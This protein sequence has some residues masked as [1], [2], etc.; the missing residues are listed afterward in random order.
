[1]ALMPEGTTEY[2]ESVQ[3]GFYT[4]EEV[5]KLS[6]KTITEP[7]FLDNLGR[8]VPG[9]LYDPALGPLDEYSICKTCGQISFQ[10]PGHW[11]RIPLALKVY[12]PL[13]FK[14]L[15]DLLKIT[16]FKCH[17][18]RVNKLQVQ[19]CVSKLELI[20]K[21]DVAGALDLVPSEKGH[22][23]HDKCVRDNSK[24]IWTSLQLSEA[25]FVLHEF[26]K[27][28]K[29]KCEKCGYK[30]PTLTCPT[31]GWIKKKMS[32][33]AV[34]SNVINE[35]KLKK[36]LPD[37]SEHES[38]LSE[39]ET[40]GDLSVVT[41]VLEDAELKSSGDVCD[42][43]PDSKIDK[44]LSSVLVYQKY[45]SS[46][47]LLP[48]EAHDRIQLLWEFETPLC[49]FI[50][51]IQ[52]ESFH[53]SKKKGNY[54]MFF[55]ESL[56]VSPIKFR[57]PS[58][59]GDTLQAN[60]QK[61]SW[62]VLRLT[63]A[64]ESDSTHSISSP[65][66]AVQATTLTMTLYS[67]MKMVMEHPQTMLLK[68]VLQSNI[69]LGNAY[70][71]KQGSKFELCCR[72]LQRSVN[73]LF[74]N[75]A[76]GQT[77]NMYAGICQLIEKKEGIFRQNMMGKRVNNAC[78]SVISPDP[79]LAVNEIG[80]P[81]H[82]ATRLTY[83]ERVTPLN[84][85]KLGIAIVNGSE[86]HPG[87]THY[88]DKISMVKLP[89]IKRKRRAIS[90]KLHSSRGVG[91]QPGEIVDNEF[92]EKFVYRHIQDGDI[93]LVNRQP[94]LHK[95]GI[96]AHVVRVLTGEKTLRMHYANCST[97]N[98]DFDG[99]EMNVHFP[100]D[101]ISRSEALNI[102]NANNQYVVPTSGD[103]KRGLIQWFLWMVN[104]T[105]VY[106]SGSYC[107]CRTSYKEGYLLTR[108]EYSHLL[109]SS[110]VSS[111]ARSSFR[112]KSGQKVSTI[113]FE[114][115]IQPVCPAILKPEPLWTGKQVITSLLNHIS[116][117][118]G[119][120]PLT[121]EKPGKIK[122][123]YFGS[124][125]G[126]DKLLIQK[127]EFVHGVIDKNQFDK[128]GLIHAIQELYSS[129]IAGILLS[130]LSRLFTVFLQMHGFTCG[131]DDLLIVP[132]L[133]IQM[134]RELQSCDVRGAKEHA[135]FVGCEDSSIDPM[136]LQLEIEK[137][138]RVN[139]E[140]AITRLDGVMASMLNVLTSNVND[141]LFPKGLLKPFPKNCLSLMTSSGAKG[142]L[143][144]FTQ[145]SSSLGQQELEGKRVP[146]M[147]SGKTLPCFPPWDSASRAGGFISDR[148]LT[149]LR[150]QEY[151]FHCMAGREGL[152]DTAV[153][154]SR[155]GYLQRCL[156]KNLEGLKVCYD[157]TVRDADN[158][159][160]QF[161]YGEDGVD[162][163]KTSFISEFNILAA[164][165]ERLSDHYEG[166][167]F[168]ES[169]GYIKEFPEALEWKAKDFI[170]KLSK[171]QL[172]S[173]LTTKQLSSKLTKKQT[174]S[175][176]L[177]KKK[178]FMELMKLKYLSSLA[179]PG[180]PVG[181]I[182]AQSIGEPSTQMT[183]NTFHH[184]GRGD[185]NVTLGIPR[186]Q[187]ILMRASENIQTPVLTCPLQNGKTENDAKCLA[188]TLNKVSVADVVESM[189]VRVEH[190]KVHKGKVST[191]YKLKM[192]LFHP[193]FYPEFSDITLEKIEEILEYRF[194][195]ELEEVI[196]SHLTMLS[197]ISG[198]NNSTQNSQFESGK[199]MDPDNI[200]NQSQ[201]VEDENKVGGVEIDSEGED[202]ADG[203]KR[204]RQSADDM[205]YEDHDEKGKT[206]VEGESSDIDGE[207]SAGESEVDEVDDVEDEI[208]GDDD[209]VFDAEDESKTEPVSKKKSSN[210]E[211]KKQK[212]GKKV[213][214]SVREKKKSDRSVYVEANGLDFEVHLKFTDEPHILLS[215]IAQRA[216]KNVY[217]KRSGKIDQ[218]S[219]TTVEHMRNKKTLALQTAGV[220]FNAFAKLQDYL[221]INFMST[222]DIHAMLHTYG[223]EA[224]RATII[225]QVEAVF[226][227]YGISVNIRHL[228]LVA[229]FMTHSGGYRPMSRSGIANST[230]P[231]SK[232]SFE[233]ASNF[234][235]QA[236]YHGEVDNLESPSARI[237]LGLPVKMGTGSFDVLLNYN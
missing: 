25:V 101:E 11:G 102:V 26:M 187:E 115:E 117:A 114:D 24:H 46:G 146:R 186:L 56:L 161:C 162:V 37:G 168:D 202:G 48:L 231:F 5:E 211:P 65:F 19:R 66:E 78:R 99:D 91:T 218:C 59:G 119:L 6:C 209:Q 89:P 130:V 133:D 204:R 12:N 64:I 230:S 228:T 159:I 111:A 220:N 128:Y 200:V 70:T 132:H 1:M 52:Q 13:L 183:L 105:F 95:P 77:A 141:Q 229:D 57:P 171:K 143:V 18:F 193:D 136:E 90:R 93:V 188:A 148:F 213:V 23:V 110:G 176:H 17:H 221:D 30:C 153:K 125:S 116:R 49:S 203:E 10:C 83:P 224:A 34:R 104:I 61:E 28:K 53:I 50:C 74:G 4:E 182:A 155:S 92:E 179:Q 41:D 100:Q 174:N 73:M 225:K 118:R 196:Q 129:E 177:E 178:K 152:V 60:H 212:K 44:K 175:L 97:Y 38:T 157:Y 145:I 120:A 194:V 185:M 222:N 29:S 86:Q 122:S 35:G 189:E 55:I 135:K 138:I 217:I 181:V 223:V 235:I 147:V 109:Y 160:I 163:H 207:T 154:T 156:I 63:A 144:N 164:N 3:F 180:E 139:G 142:S 69:S 234:I 227:P 108:D 84:V 33:N 31:F 197:K 71:N 45:K 198:I 151:Y 87:A 2:V 76:S 94:T 210:R 215:Q 58:K 214:K 236:A 169:N 206:A 134:R 167:V 190:F 233:T 172:N 81:P 226:K 237:C 96:M 21:G 232:M 36:Q 43:T 79:Y 85:R 22:E 127:N 107:G 165:L 103:P 88:A 16:C 166:A 20:I 40:M 8:P 201:L 98:A 208:N 113:N 67:A 47:V 62:N 106:S 72:E 126:E 80:I 158:S 51:D 27:V 82:F 140:S 184:A 15:Y 195:R 39:D 150:P 216:A 131:V 137:V 191:I 32:D 75:K 192:K 173:M 42:G 205:D 7:V 54:S 14:I 68:K 149:G 9:S 121:V 219:V 123:E 170:S 112:G 199:E 124:N